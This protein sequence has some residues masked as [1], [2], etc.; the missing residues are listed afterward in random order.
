MSIKVAADQL[1]PADVVVKFVRAEVQHSRSTKNPYVLHN[2]SA[3][4]FSGGL[5]VLRADGDVITTHLSR[6]IIWHQED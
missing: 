1:R 4:I 5:F 3:S 2:G 6:C